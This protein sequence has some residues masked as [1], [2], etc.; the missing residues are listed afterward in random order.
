M[1]RPK[2]STKKDTTKA[3]SAK[4]SAT[5][6]TQKS[7]TETR[8]KP[9]PTYK[10]TTADHDADER[11]ASAALMMLGHDKTHRDT[12]KTR[13]GVVTNVQVGG[14]DDD[15]NSEVMDDEEPEEEDEEI[16]RDDNEAQNAEDMDGAEQGG[17][18]DASD[19]SCGMVHHISF[20]LNIYLPSNFSYNHPSTQL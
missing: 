5:G 1:T 12:D 7:V 10:A 11:V 15:D 17:N 8:P 16:D 9:R 3:R 13:S 4:G 2:K 20:E 19:I 18:D 14:L 6:R